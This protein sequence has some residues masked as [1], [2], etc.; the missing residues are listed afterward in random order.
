MT[1]KAINQNRENTF[2]KDADI[3]IVIGVSAH[4]NID[5]AF[6]GE[7]QS[8]VGEFLDEI[9]KLCPHSSIYMLTG[10][11]QGGDLLCARVAKEKGIKIIVALPFETLDG[12]PYDNESDFGNED[13]HEY[14]ELISSG[15]IIKKFI[16]PDIEGCAPKNNQKE[17][18][19][20]LFR[21]QAIYVSTN[22]HV[23]LTLWDGSPHANSRLECGTNSA[24]NFALEN[25]FY[26]PDGME[27]YSAYSGAVVG[28]Y[29]PR[30]GREYPAFTSED[31]KY[32]YIESSGLLKKKK[33]LK[34]S[35]FTRGKELSNLVA[36]K[37]MPR[38][39]KDA[40]V[41]TDTYNDDY[42]K[43]CATLK[44]PKKR[45]K[46]EL[47][48]LVNHD[49][50][51]LHE[52]SKP[53]HDCCRVSS[54]LSAK[55]KNKYLTGIKWLSVFG[56]FLILSWVLYDQIAYRW[57]II[58]CAIMLLTLVIGYITVNFSEA[59]KLAVKLKLKTSF[60]SH[61]KFVEYR[62]LSETLR[63][64]YYLLTLGLT[65]N[66]CN[67][68]SWGHKCE[69]HW[70]KMGVTAF[71]I[72]CHDEKWQSD[73][74]KEVL[75]K[76]IGSKSE[77]QGKSGSGQLGYHQRNS[78]KQRK[79]IT[80]RNIVNWIT[81]G[82]TFAIYVTLFTNELFGF[83][84]LNTALFWVINAR[85]LLKGGLGIFTAITFFLSYNYSKQSLDQNI[86]DSLHMAD[87][88]RMALD[89]ISSIQVICHNETDRVHEMKSLIRELA[90][91]QLIENATWVA[92]NRDNGND[93]P[94]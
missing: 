73:T 92:Y 47:R 85:M 52:E 48:Y 39:L 57:T 65:E 41:R 45:A 72:G 27:F 16:V 76:W 8:Q 6:Y 64:Q 51:Q 71:L 49:I 87:L 81:V 28:I 40:L 21:Q 91:N 54:I 29:S 58:V 89:R 62:A 14:R 61:A 68:F 43:Y 93:V 37:K 90:R 22:C 56:V 36:V 3:P 79:K 1:N 60:D 46:E 70:V 5:K 50:Y 75:K 10:L 74:E 33:Q 9:L 83:W 15:H 42:L 24:V 66:A 35:V 55:N 63:V 30:E 86:R 69:L 31:F 19:K 7:I 82:C 77:K 78:M 25:N 2:W 84:D 53:I 94:I 23:L 67:L 20:Y 18:R 59:T 13:L 44:N 32:Q 38:S 80:I 12:I 11:A 88:Y 34:E 26:R 17:L 4:R